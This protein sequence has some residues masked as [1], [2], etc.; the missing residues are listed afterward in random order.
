[1]SVRRFTTLIT[2]N[3]FEKILKKNLETTGNNLP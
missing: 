3:L 1:M 2:T